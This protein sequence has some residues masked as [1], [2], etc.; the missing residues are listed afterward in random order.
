[1]LIFA[2]QERIR[3]SGKHL[4]VRVYVPI[5]KAVVKAETMVDDLEISAPTVEVAP[6]KSKR[7]K[8]KAPVRNDV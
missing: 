6:E 7:A 4:D 2:A 8:R 1:M 3:K 5:M